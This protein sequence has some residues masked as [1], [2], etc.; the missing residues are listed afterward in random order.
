[1]ARERRGGGSDVQV[2]KLLR[3]AAIPLVVVVLIGII[4]YMDRPEGGDGED[5]VLPTVIAK[6]G[7]TKA[8]EEPVTDRDAESGDGTG[9]DGETTGEGEEEGLTQEDGREADPAQ[10]PLQQ[11]TVL[12]LTGLVQSYCEAK[13]ECDPELLAWVFGITDWSEEAKE[14]ERSRM[15]LVKASVKGYENISCYTVQGPEPDTYVIFP[16]YE[17]HYRETETLM[18]AFSWGYVKKDESGRYYM[19][20][21]TD[22]P[23]N[24]YIRRVGEKAEVKAVMAQILARQQEAIA[25]DP[26]LQG[27]YGS[28]GESEVIIGGV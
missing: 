3:F 20:Q 8:P 13:E 28:S 22:T 12:E 10:Y 17:I 7:L 23:V 15:E 21:V 11:D 27:I 18:P 9:E 2:G 1:M 26:I 24:D 19:V 25:Q 5:S 6:A 4:I 16:Y 14:E